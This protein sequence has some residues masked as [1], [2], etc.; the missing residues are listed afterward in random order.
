M[1]KGNP[2]ISQGRMKQGEFASI[3]W[4][5]TPEEGTTREHIERPEYFSHVAHKFKPYQT[6]LR[7]IPEDGVFYAEY[8]VTACDRTWAKVKLLNYVELAGEM[9]TSVISED[10]E[11][12]L[13]GQKRWSV[14]RK[15]DRTVLSE[16]H[17]HKA[18]AQQW[19][20]MYLKQAAAA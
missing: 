15:A 4:D 16:N 19:L 7:V 5:I 8:V 1:E 12:K 6:Y 13:R 11:V 3:V 17:F 20:M 18:D 2:K 10:Y 9:D 14:I